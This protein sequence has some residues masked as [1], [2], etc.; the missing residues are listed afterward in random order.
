MLVTLHKW[1]RGRAPRMPKLPG[2]VLSVSQVAQ[3]PRRPV[4]HIASLVH[5]GGS[6]AASP[7]CQLQ[8]SLAS[9][10]F[11]TTLKVFVALAESSSVTTVDSSCHYPAA[12]GPPPALILP[13]HALRVRPLAPVVNTAPVLHESSNAVFFNASVEEN[14]GELCTLGP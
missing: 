12:N 14:T 13:R 10:G 5:S 2:V 3:R 4:P 8:S 1:H 7:P 11:S 9:S 6:L